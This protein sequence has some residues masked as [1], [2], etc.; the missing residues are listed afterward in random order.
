[1]GASANAFRRVERVPLADEIIAQIVERIRS[2]S[3]RPGD[4]LPTELELVE[5]FGV[6]RSSVREALKGLEILG[7]VTRTNS[8]TFISATSPASALTRYLSAD[9][10]ARR[11]EV[12]D[13]YEA[14]RILEVEL[15][16]LALRNVSGHDIEYL[17]E[18]ADRMAATPLEDLDAYMDL[19][20]VFHSEICNLSGNAILATMWLI[21]YDVFAEIR[22]S[23]PPTDAFRRLSDER[24]RLLVQA[25]ASGDP[26]HVRRTVSESLAIGEKDIVQALEKAR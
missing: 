15:T 12:V 19:D 9:F 20:R 8:G 25:L 24:H 2:G 5:Q 10:I 18:L 13:V 4:R 16:T 21:A 14:R 6:S 26:D 17:R 1:M 23:V 11:L 3:L 22:R 7:I